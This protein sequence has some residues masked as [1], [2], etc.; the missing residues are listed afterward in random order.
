MDPWISA[1]RLSET[2]RAG[3]RRERRDYQNKVELRESA[4]SG[5]NSNPGGVPVII[6][7]V[8]TGHDGKGA[9]HIVEDGATPR[10]DA[11]QHIP[12]MVS[13]LVWATTVVS[14]LPYNG[15]DPTP[16]VTSFVPAPGETR[17]LIV[18][19]PPDSVFSGPDFNPSEAAAENLAV[20]PGLAEYF[21]PDGTHA[22][23]TIDYGVV[24]DGE[25]WLE[26]DSHAERLC[27]H[28]IV[29]QNG[30]RHAWRNRTD[31]PTTMAFILIGANCG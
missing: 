11:F 12:G 6:R 23:P 25:I 19:F 15:I 17:F 13:R 30:T 10:T 29:I 7:R 14:K 28:D 22:T 9:A 8:V 20:S 27:R 1:R 24:L 5:E 4:V 21:E 3:A 2:L 26:L 18:T 16:S 31:Q